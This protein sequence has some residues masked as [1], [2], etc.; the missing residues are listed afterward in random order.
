M[1]YVVRF[2]RCH[3]A[4]RLIDGYVR[5]NQANYPSHVDIDLVSEKRN[6]YEPKNAA[7]LANRNEV[8]ISN[9]HI[10]IASTTFKQL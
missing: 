6:E 8:P 7:N 4:Y 1:K 3:M 5:I 9:S 2:R 10:W